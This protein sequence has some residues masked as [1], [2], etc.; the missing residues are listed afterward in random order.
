MAL[1]ARQQAQQAT[2]DYDKV[3]SS[4]HVLTLMRSAII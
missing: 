4:R 2:V 3:L 1:R